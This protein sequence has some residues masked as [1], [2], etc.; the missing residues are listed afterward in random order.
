MKEKFA[1]GFAPPEGGPLE[2]LEEKNYG[3]KKE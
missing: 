3:K 2:D 1:A